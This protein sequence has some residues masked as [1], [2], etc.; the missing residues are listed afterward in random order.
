MK[1]NDIK[2]YIAFYLGDRYR[3][4]NWIDNLK[5]LKPR[6]KNELNTNPLIRIRVSMRRNIEKDI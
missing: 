3:I 5:S 4:L 2:L 6:S 1:T